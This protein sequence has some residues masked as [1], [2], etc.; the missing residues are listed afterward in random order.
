MM[1][2]WR[3]LQVGL[4]LIM[5]A[6]VPA[7]VVAVRDMGTGA[8]AEIV[9]VGL[10]P[11]HVAVDARTGR[12]FVTNN[13]GNSLSVLDAHSG[14]VLRTVSVG[15]SPTSVVVNGRTG[16]AF[17]LN[18]NDGSVSVLDAA[19]GSV[20]RTVQLPMVGAVAVDEGTG[21]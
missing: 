13:S 5:L 11:G 17:V 20:L 15:S 19:T 21:H 16:R 3:W 14:D 7:G 1:R 18:D 4:V 6:V 12:A 10:S 2:P 8:G 9:P